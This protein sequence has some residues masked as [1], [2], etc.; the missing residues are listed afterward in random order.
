M[1]SPVI[2]V[3]FALR[4]DPPTL[5]M[6]FRRSAGGKRKITKFQLK[7]LKPTSVR[8][9]VIAVVHVCARAGFF[10]MCVGVHSHSLPLGQRPT[11]PASLPPTLTSFSL[12]SLHPLARACISR[13]LSNVPR[14]RPRRTPKRS[15]AGS[16]ASVRRMW[17]PTLSQRSS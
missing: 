3:R 4:Y 5:V 8:R 1:A 7:R 16:S 17:G 6:E 14:A 12:P 9:V 11:S 13:V 10:C 15:S 2:P